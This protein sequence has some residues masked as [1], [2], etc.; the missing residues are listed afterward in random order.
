MIRRADMPKSDLLPTS[1][2]GFCSLQALRVRPAIDFATDFKR[3]L[4]ATIEVTLLDLAKQADETGKQHPP[5][6]PSEADLDNLLRQLTERLNRNSEDL[7]ALH[8][9]G[10][11]LLKNASFT[12]GKGCQ[13]A[14]QD[15]KEVHRRDESIAAARFG[16]GAMY[17]DMVIFDLVKRGLY[18]MVKTGSV[19]TIE[20]QPFDLETPQFVSPPSDRRT[21]MLLLPAL[22]ELL[23]G[24]SLKQRYKNNS[25]NWH[26]LDML[27]RL[28]SVRILLGY[29]M[30]VPPDQW[31]GRVYSLMVARIKTHLVPEMYGLASDELLAPATQH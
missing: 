17:L 30:P 31:I 27:Y 4:V 8:L 12:G 5:I 6:P 25:P 13:Q 20:G 11:L 26:P 9:R 14:I 19:Q 29:E 28:R 7:D 21:M 23:A 22:E 15:F 1:L 10:M 2:Q 24:F 18:K 16:L 3:L